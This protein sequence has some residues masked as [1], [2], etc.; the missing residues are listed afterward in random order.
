M[1]I[2]KK[3][4]HGGEPGDVI[5]LGGPRRRRARAPYTPNTRLYPGVRASKKKPKGSN[6]KLHRKKKM[7]PASQLVPNPRLYQARPRRV[8]PPPPPAWPA[9]SWAP[10]APAAC[11]ETASGVALRLAERRAEQS[12]QSPP[13]PP[14]CCAAAAK[15]QL[16]RPARPRRARRRP[17]RPIRDPA[18][19][20]NV[21]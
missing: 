17:Q 14:V 12:A 16:A 6:T 15:R 7:R 20:L 5:D 9:V 4:E 2:K 13:P 10:R 3:K 21:K 8:C 19:K 1:V 11:L 18:H